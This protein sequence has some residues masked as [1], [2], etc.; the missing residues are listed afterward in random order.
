MIQSEGY[1]ND[2]YVVPVGAMDV[3]MLLGKDL[4]KQMDIRILN[5][6]MTIRKTVTKIGDGTPT[7]GLKMK[8]VRS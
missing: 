8:N 4:H 6:Q 1:R 2:V 7:Q 3:K 5:G